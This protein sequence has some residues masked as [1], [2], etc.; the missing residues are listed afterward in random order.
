MQF[1]DLIPV[2]GQEILAAREIER[3]L[4]FKSGHAGIAD[5]MYVIGEIVVDK[6]LHGASTARIRIYRIV[7]QPLCYE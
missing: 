6:E 7:D 4:L 5:S 2:E 3:A 1:P